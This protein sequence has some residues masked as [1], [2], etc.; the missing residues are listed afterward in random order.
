M[1]LAL[2]AIAI[3]VLSGCASVSMESKD[4]SDAAK[5]FAAPPAGSAGIYIFRSGGIGGALKR[6]LWINGKCLGRSAPDVFFFEEVKGGEELTV[7]TESEFSPN[8]LLVKTIAG[9][10][11]FI[12]QYMKMG[13]FVG[14]ANLELVSEDIGK[15]A[16]A[17]LALATKG[18]CSK[19]R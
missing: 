5:L 14:G 18:G 15:K 1:R 2:A 19:A 8:D 6:D 9:N 3:A 13:V 10:N 16:V 17:E 12:R 11:Y 4:K 7:S